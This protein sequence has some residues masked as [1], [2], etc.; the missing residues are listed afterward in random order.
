MAIGHSVLRQHR[1][2]RPVTL[3]RPFPFIRRAT[4][5]REISDRRIQRSGH[6]LRA[7]IGRRLDAIFHVDARLLSDCGV[8]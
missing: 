4:P 5:A 1:A 8:V 2:E 6:D 3:H 7:D